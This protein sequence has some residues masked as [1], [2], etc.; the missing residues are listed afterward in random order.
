M[1]WK[2]ATAVLTLAL[3]YLLVRKQP[4]LVLAEQPFM[5]VR[6]LQECRGEAR[7]SADLVEQ[8]RADGALCRYDLGVE[9]RLCTH[10]LTDLEERL[11]VAN[12]LAE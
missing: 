6:Q 4:D 7:A 10:E 2:I 3:A 12:S 5:V 11:A 8:L 9:R 1:R